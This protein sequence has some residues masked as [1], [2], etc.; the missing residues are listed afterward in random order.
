MAQI[1]IWN[2]VEGQEFL[3]N[4]YHQLADIEKTL[5]HL[6][7]DKNL[8]IVEQESDLVISKYGEDVFYVGVIRNG[9]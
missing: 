2:I 7:G 6:T 9:N 4:D 1:K 5:R 3:V 8:C